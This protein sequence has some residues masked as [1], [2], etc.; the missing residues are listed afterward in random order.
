MFD[1]PELHLHPNAIAN[2]LRMLY[3]LLE[4][5]NF[6]AII[7]THSPLIVQEIPFEYVLILSRLENILSVRRAEKERFGDNVTT[8]TY[9]IFD[10]CGTENNYKTVLKSLSKK[11]SFDEVIGLFEGRL[12]FNA[13]IY[14]KTCYKDE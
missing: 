6:Y 10:V 7:A 3:K 14:L 13:L 1:E 4:E 12:S 9:D 2:I 11:L 5:F 8:I